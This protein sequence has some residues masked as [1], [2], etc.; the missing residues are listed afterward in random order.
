MEDVK[1]MSWRNINAVWI[2]SPRV[3]RLG[4]GAMWKYARSADRKW[5]VTLRAVNFYAPTAITPMKR[6]S[7]IAVGSV[8]ADT[9]PL[10][11]IVN[12]SYTPE[13]TQG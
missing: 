8:E 13:N 4:K 3:I 11:T 1:W 7:S 5:N 9:L 10:S 12:F 6:I 2:P